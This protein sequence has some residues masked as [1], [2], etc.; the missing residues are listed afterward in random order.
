[1]PLAQA[2]IKSRRSAA[3]AQATPPGPS[4]PILAKTADIASVD[5]GSH[6][7]SSVAY[8]LRL[9]VDGMAPCTVPK[10]DAMPATCRFTLQQAPE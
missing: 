9:T 7:A 1:V 3:H 5:G 2:P 4:R 10:L 8:I 6:P